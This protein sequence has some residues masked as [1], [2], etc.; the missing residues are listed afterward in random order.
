[1][2]RAT[3]RESR[4]HDRAAISG[5]SALI[6]QS[7]GGTTSRH[8]V[9]N[10]SEHGLGID[11]LTLAVGAPISFLIAGHGI[12][13]LGRGRVAHRTDTITGVAVDRWHG[14]PEAIRG[15]IAGEAEL[16]QRLAREAA[17]VTDWS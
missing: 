13:H 14:A 16:G 11:G 1:M 4:E 10:M 15:L 9:L 5:L 2:T 7:P 17:Y 12:S 6:E 3:V 8:H